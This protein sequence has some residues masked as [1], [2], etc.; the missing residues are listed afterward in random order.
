MKKSLIT[1]AIFFLM[2]SSAVIAHASLDTFLS[3]LNIRARAD[4]DNF[5]G[6]LSAQF[7]IPLPQV[8]AIIKTVPLPADAF[9]C[10]QLSQII[11]KPPERVIQIYNSNK[12]KGWG[13]IAKELGIKP[14]SAAFHAL[15]RGD[16]KLTGNRGENSGKTQGKGKGKN[17]G[18]GKGHN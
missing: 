14:G 8:R 2:A 4:M 13:A 12:K 5:G 11:N 18:K 15:K 10:L 7:N 1:M 16:F 3:G 6:K 17:K 9:M